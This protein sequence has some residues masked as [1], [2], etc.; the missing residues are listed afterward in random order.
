[1]AN[2][3]DSDSDGSTSS[4]SDGL[5]NTTDD[6]SFNVALFPTGDEGSSFRTQND[7][8]D[9]YQRTNYIGWY[10]DFPDS[11]IVLKRD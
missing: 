7:P 1:M 11:H 8:S 9:P 5:T 4:V 2:F 6:L 10:W 3:G